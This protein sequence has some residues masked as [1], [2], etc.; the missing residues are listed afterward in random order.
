MREEIKQMRAAR[1][2][3]KSFVN[4]PSLFK[5]TIFRFANW[6]ISTGKQLRQRFEVPAEPC[7]NTPTGNF[8]N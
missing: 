3:F 2:A 7:N 6:M 4:H 1:L 5:R 8:A